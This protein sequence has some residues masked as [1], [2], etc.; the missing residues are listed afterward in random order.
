V[1][2]GFRLFII[3]KIGAFLSKIGFFLDNK[4]GDE[5]IS[6][7]AELKGRICPVILGAFRQKM[8]ILY[9]AGPRYKETGYY[10]TFWYVPP[11][12][13]DESMKKAFHLRL[14]KSRYHIV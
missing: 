4:I 6:N 9:T 2:D 7:G 13:H 8:Q 12:V 11:S 5:I 1:I 3:Y 14:K 10:Y